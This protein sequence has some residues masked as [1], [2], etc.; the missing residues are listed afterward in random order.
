MDV[1]SS[2]VGSAKSCVQQTG[3]SQ[4]G[5]HKGSNLKKDPGSDEEAR[6][7]G[8]GRGW[9]SPEIIPVSECG[10][11]VAIRNYGRDA[12]KRE[13]SLSDGSQVGG[14]RC[15]RGGLRKRSWGTP[16]FQGGG[17]RCGGTVLGR[18]KIKRGGGEEVQSWKKKGR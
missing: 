15:R 8:K 10:C 5:V 18:G 14:A 11:E 13:G 2:N 16:S 1:D 4:G 9:S 17:S 3:V 12:N 6:V 7:A